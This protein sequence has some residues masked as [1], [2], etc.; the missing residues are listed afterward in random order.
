MQQELIHVIDTAILA[1]HELEASNS[2][3]FTP[4]KTSLCPPRHAT[5]W[6]EA[7]AWM[8]S[9]HNGE[10]SQLWETAQGEVACFS[11]AII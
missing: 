9:Q 11:L 5:R 7:F 6:A 2:I 4:A 3:A 1:L 8:Q 10:K